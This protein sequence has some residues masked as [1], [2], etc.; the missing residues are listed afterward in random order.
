MLG[1][2]QLE[3]DTL[4]CKKIWQSV[5]LRAWE[6]ATGGFLVTNEGKDT[7]KRMRTE[8]RKW[9]MEGGE[10]LRMVC[11]WA[12]MDVEAVVERS[13]EEFGQNVRPNKKV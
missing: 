13:R 6:D 8:A 12:G 1:P 2:S 5:I 7:A 11:E 9:L 4:A 10:D 3:R